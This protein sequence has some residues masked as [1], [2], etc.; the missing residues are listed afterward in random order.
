MKILVVGDGHSAIHEVAVAA[1][2]KKLGHEVESFYWQDYFK[3]R[4][5]IRRLWRRA[6]N[7]FLIGPS[8]N[9]LNRDL[10][11]QAIQ[12]EPKLI[13]I[14]R[15]THIVSATIVALKRTFPDCKIFGY[16]NDDP[17]ASGHPFWLWRHFLKSVPVYN[18][19]F[20]YRHHNLD[21][22][23]KFGAKRVELL[24]SWFVPELNHFVS[25]S[26][27]D[28]LK[29]KC[30]VV[31]IGH[32]ENDGRFELLEEIVKAGY[33]L[34]L[35]GPPYE[36]NKLL[37]QSEILK[38]LYPVHLVWN[39]DYNKAISG[40]KVALCFFSK[41]NRDTYT[42]RCF[43]IPATGTVLLSEYSDDM[44][45]IYQAGKE[46]DYFSSKDELIEKVKLYVENDSL[47]HQVAQCGNLRVVKDGHDIVS[48]MSKVITFVGDGD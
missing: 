11:L 19:V 12:F 22:F 26:D 38:Y 43:E 32:Y 13:F 47:R 39:D 3:S 28:K 40:A 25:I 17:F 7:K 8:F 46:A 21:E 23:I 6:Q 48:R 27:E 1:A 41:L 35:F 34:R 24:R 15:G 33:V 16:N 18:L 31:F 10:F 36:W 42:R 45:T 20:A 14:Y 4:N 2:F 9:K 30:D 29:Y 44:A 37:L 5:P